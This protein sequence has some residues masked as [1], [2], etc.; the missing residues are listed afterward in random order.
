[1]QEFLYQ[2]TET[3][4]FSKGHK[5]DIQIN[6]PE[7]Y[8]KRVCLRNFGFKFGSVFGVKNESVV[9]CSALFFKSI[10]KIEKNPAQYLKMTKIII[11]AF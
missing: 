11:K 9:S 3:L 7:T 6:L 4:F 5:K 1:M 2:V 8:R 10:F